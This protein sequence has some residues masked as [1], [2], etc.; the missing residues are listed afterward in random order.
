MEILESKLKKIGVTSTNETL[1]S[2]MLSNDVLSKEELYS[3]IALGR[4]NLDNLKK[5]IKKNP[6]NNV[7]KYWE[8]KLI[9]SK[10]D[11]KDI[12]ESHSSFD[13]NVPFLLRENVENAEQS[14]EIAKCCNPIPGDEVTGYH[15]PEGTI[16]IHKPKCPVAIRIMSNEGNR[17]IAVKWAIHKLVSFLARISMTGIDRIGL[18]NDITTI[19]S[20]E[21]K[22]NMTRINIT[23]NNGIF[24]GTIDLYVHHTKDLNNLILKISNI[25]GIENVRRVEDFSN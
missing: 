13:K 12:G 24:E 15:S 8:L 5:S 20:A 22:V 2:I 7:I 16:I 19:I 25:N 11:K 10:K 14:Y 21:L 17:I 18:V 3:G 1:K 6:A 23:V 9:G 4:I